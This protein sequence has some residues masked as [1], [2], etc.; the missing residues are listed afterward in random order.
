MTAAHVVR[1]HLQQLP[2]CRGTALHQPFRGTRQLRCL[3]TIAPHLHTSALQL[4]HLV[5]STSVRCCASVL[6]S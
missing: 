1:T 3:R 6:R 2:H 5:A 4:Q